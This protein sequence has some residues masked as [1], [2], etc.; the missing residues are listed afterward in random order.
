M[1]IIF[2]LI[3][4]SQLDNAVNKNPWN[5]AASRISLLLYQNILKRIFF[6]LECFAFTNLDTSQ[7]LFRLKLITLIN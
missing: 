3:L 1:E 6:L 2:F 5:K 7:H 4:T